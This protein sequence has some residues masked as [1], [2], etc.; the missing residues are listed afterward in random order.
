[1]SQSYFGESVCA[2]RLSMLIASVSFFEYAY[3]CFRVFTGKPGAGLRSRRRS[4]PGDGAVATTTAAA[5]A[6]AA[7]GRAAAVLGQGE[8]RLI[9]EQHAVVEVETAQRAATAASE[10]AESV[11]VHLTGTAERALEVELSEQRRTGEGELEVCVRGEEL[12]VAQR[13]TAERWQLCDVVHQ[14]ARREAVAV[15]EIQAAQ[16]AVGHAAEQGDHLCAELPAV[17]Q[18]HFA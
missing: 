4:T 11:V 13:E 2:V 18:T 16:S 10:S 14:R 3:C 12:A 8:Q 5:A 1:M 9:R 6:A 15:A 7:A 17:G